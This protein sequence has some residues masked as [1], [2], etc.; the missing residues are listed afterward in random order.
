MPKADRRLK[1]LVNVSGEK[2]KKKKTPQP[3]AKETE[4]II[5]GCTGI[6]CEVKVMSVEHVTTAGIVERE[7]VC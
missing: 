7:G 3:K 2:K 6:G 1:S 5:I 4:Q